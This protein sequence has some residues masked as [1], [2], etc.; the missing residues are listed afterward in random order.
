MVRKGTIAPA[1]GCVK[2]PLVP[3]VSLEV[4]LDSFMS[5]NASLYAI[6]GCFMFYLLRAPR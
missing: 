3:Y 5:L 6:F 2:K 4:S 1:V